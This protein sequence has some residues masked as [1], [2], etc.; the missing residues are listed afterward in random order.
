MGTA[1]ASMNT[2]L[3]GTEAEILTS[4]V[5]RRDGR[6]C[7]RAV[8]KPVSPYLS[9]RNHP[10]PLPHHSVYTATFTTPTPPARTST[11]QAKHSIQ[12]PGNPP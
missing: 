8:N 3:A 7:P 2:A 10:D 4:L 6:V 1:R 5:P 9:K 11:D 12:H